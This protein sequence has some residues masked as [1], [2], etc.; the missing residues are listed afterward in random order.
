MN[1]NLYFVG[2]LL[3]AVGFFLTLNQIFYGTPLAEVLWF[4]HK[5]FYY[6]VPCAFV[7]FI[8]VFVCGIASLR[9]L[10]TREGR[11]DD[12]AEAAGELAVV[13]GAIVLTTG[14]IW[15]KAA[16]EHWW[17]W[18]L[19]LTTSLL[20]WL[21]ML[22]YVLVRKYAGAGSERLAAGLAVFGMV[23]VP[24]IY[25]S[26]KIW[27]GLHPKTSTVPTLDPTMRATF[28]GSVALFIVFYVILLVTRVGQSRSLR[29]LREARERGLDTGLFD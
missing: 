6:H 27:G 15:G 21:I 13:F 9:Y 19:R 26:V 3:C 4:N 7:L 8:S 28:W 10:R 23:D 24:L 29:E 16:W 12:Y 11:F 17:V 2:A 18:E 20:L 14:M 5:I 1:R 22:G 25:F